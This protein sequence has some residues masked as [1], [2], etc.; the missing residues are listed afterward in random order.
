MRKNGFFRKI[1]KKIEVHREEITEAVKK[2]GGIITGVVFMGAGVV[3]LHM[4]GVDISALGETSTSGNT[5]GGAADSAAAPSP[6]ERDKL[7]S[8]AIEKILLATDEAMYDTERLKAAQNIR[9]IAMQKGLSNAKIVGLNALTDIS[10]QV[11]Y[12]TTREKIAGFI[13]EIAVSQ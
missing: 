11:T 10:K 2:V 8:E 9:D 7:A 13:G 4:N 6:E 12:T 1:G 3:I 5:V